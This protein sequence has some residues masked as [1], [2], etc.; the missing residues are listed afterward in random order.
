MVRGASPDVT[1]VAGRENC[2]GC[3]SSHAEEFRADPDE[4]RIGEG[5]EVHP[6]LATYESQRAWS[7]GEGRGEGVGVR[8]AEEYAQMLDQMQVR[9]CLFFVRPQHVAQVISRYTGLLSIFFGYVD[10]GNAHAKFRADIARVTLKSVAVYWAL[11]CGTLSI[12]TDD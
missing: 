11:R 5:T 9:F 6:G 1:A 7:A 8:G 12:R 3:V 2:K 10:T 4:S